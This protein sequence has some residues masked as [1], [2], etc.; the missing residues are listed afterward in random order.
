MA[1]RQVTHAHRD[2]Q[3]IILAVCWKSGTSLMYTARQQ[4]VDDI[5]SGAHRYYVHEQ[6][7]AVWIE[8]ITV[9]GVQYIKTEADST[10]QN[11][12]DNLPTC[13]QKAG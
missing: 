11:N 4:V 2:D 7:P 1:D 12:L 13:T 3:G 10:S 9:N 6:A 8:V 5:S